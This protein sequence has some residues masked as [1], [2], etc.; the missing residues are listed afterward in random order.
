MVAFTTPEAEFHPAPGST[1]DLLARLIVEQEK[2]RLL[3]ETVEDY[4]QALSDAADRH[5]KLIEQVGRALDL[6]KARNGGG[7]S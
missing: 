1:I 3:T 6:L 2:V 4:R 5:D 7:L